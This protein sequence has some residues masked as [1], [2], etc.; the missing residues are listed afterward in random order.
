MAT[1]YS[2]YRRTPT[3]EYLVGVCTNTLCAIMG[4]DA[5]LE[6]LQDHL[7]I[8]AGQT[9]DGRP[10]HAGARRVQRRVRL[11]AR[12]DGQLGVLRQPD[13]VVGTRTRRRAARR[14][15]PVTPPAARR[16]ARSAKPRESSRAC[17]SGR[18]DDVDRAATLAGLRVARTG[19]W[20]R[21]PSR[22]TPTRPD[23]ERRRMARTSPHRPS[24]NVPT[25]NGIDMTLTPVLSRFWDDPSPGRWTPTARHDGYQALAARAGAWRPTSHRDRQGL[26]S[27]RP[28]RRRV[29]DRHQMVVHPA[30]RHRRR[31][32]AALPGGQRRRVGTRYVQR[33]S[34]DVG[35]AALPGRGRDHRGVR[36]PGA[37]RVHLRPRR[38]GAGAAPTAGRGRRGVRGRLP[39]HATSKARASIWN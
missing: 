16:C 22:A 14:R 6:A 32:Q 31:R 19:A 20:R 39:G 24:A 21:L 2:M 33:H 8:H 3:G 10:G 13:A 34:A 17:R 35:H 9:T 15:A 4:G 37:P 7:G 23:D 5:I 18:A 36:D 28:R 11:R 25:R 1:F 30:G 27:A 29:P 12:R 26:G 38:G